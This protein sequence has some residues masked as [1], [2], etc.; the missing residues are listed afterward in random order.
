M[1]VP[2]ALAPVRW[3]PIGHEDQLSLVGH[4]DELRSRL[5]VSLATLAVAFGICF[6]QNTALL[7]LIDRPLS[8][9]TQ[10]QVR[11][12]HGP[13][14]ATYKVQRGA[15]DIARQLDT[16]VAVLGARSR[17]PAVTASLAGVR[18]SLQRDVAELSAPHSFLSWTLIAACRP[19]RKSG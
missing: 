11:A 1:Q 13:L 3:R 6:W 17:T 16:V 15:R 19:T 7:H 2:N 12:G 10:Q 9:Q 5:I 18:H 8:H 14:G 4:L